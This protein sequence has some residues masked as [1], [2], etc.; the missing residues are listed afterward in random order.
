MYFNGKVPRYFNSKAPRYHHRRCA[1]EGRFSTK[2]TSRIWDR[3]AEGGQPSGGVSPVP[4]G[5]DGGRLAFYFC[6]DA[7]FLMAIRTSPGHSVADYTT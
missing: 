5:A 7:Y 4:S 2:K 1:D 6:P 3:H